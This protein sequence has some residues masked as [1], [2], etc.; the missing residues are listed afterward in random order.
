[1]PEK[2]IITQN[3]LAR[4]IS[5][6]VFM[7]SRARFIKKHGFNALVVTKLFKELFNYL[8]FISLYTFNKNGRGRV[9]LT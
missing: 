8:I 9:I 1:M 3:S 6:A 2:S 4:Q 5:T 7:H